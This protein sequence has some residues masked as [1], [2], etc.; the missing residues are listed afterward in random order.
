[1]GKVTEPDYR[2]MRLAL[3]AEAV[4]LLRMERAA[5]SE[6]VADPSDPP[7]CPRCGADVAARSRFCSQC[8]FQLIN[9]ESPGEAKTA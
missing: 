2:E 3:R 7:G 6:P 5:I 4:D 9:R 8:G 1:M